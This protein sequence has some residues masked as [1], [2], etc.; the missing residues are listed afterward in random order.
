MTK[1]K[2][3]QLNAGT[4]MALGVIVASLI[5]LLISTITGNQDIWAWSVPVGVSVG[6]AIGVSAES[7]QAGGK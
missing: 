5:A 2:K 7:R 1:Q 4:G 6:L 3:F